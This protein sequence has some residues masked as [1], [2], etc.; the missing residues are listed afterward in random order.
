MNK[1]LKVFVFK[2]ATNVCDDN[3]ASL[4]ILEQ[5]VRA[6]RRSVLPAENENTR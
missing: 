3:S 2:S 1:Y 6:H 4:H 5:I